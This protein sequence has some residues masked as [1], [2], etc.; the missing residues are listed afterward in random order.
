MSRSVNKI[1]LVGHVGRDP[2]F[3]RP[4]TGPRSRT[5]RWPRTTA[6]WA[7]G[8]EEKERTEWHRLTLWNRLALFAEEYVRK[9]DRVYVEGRLEYDSYERDGV[10]IPT[11][12]V[13]VHELVLLSPPREGGGGSCGMYDGSR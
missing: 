6:P 7:N 3:G 4:R 11:A 5:S 8:D 10:T 2:E 1:I 9:G 13:H 12:E